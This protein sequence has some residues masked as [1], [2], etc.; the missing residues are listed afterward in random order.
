MHIKFIQT[1]LHHINKS[2]WS[3][4]PNLLACGLLFTFNIWRQA[5]WE[6]Q[7][8][9]TQVPRVCPLFITLCCPLQWAAEKKQ[10]GGSEESKEEGCRVSAHWAGTSSRLCPE[11]THSQ[12]EHTRRAEEVRGNRT[13]EQELR[14]WGADCGFASF[15]WPTKPIHAFTYAVQIFLRFCF[16]HTL[17]RWAA[18]VFRICLCY[19]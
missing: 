10:K 3:K 15:I 7:F 16:Y 12:K 14:W 6:M 5:S 19:V 9:I 1:Y 13:E 4:L 17:C 8:K 18:F 11:L 2:I